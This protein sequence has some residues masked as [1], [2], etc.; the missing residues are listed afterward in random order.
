MNTINI[1]EKKCKFRIFSRNGC[2][3]LASDE[4]SIIYNLDKKENTSC[5][6]QIYTKGLSKLFKTII[7]NWILY[8]LFINKA[9][10]YDRKC[11]NHL[12]NNLVQIDNE[13]QYFESQIRCNSTSAAVADK[14]YY[15]FF[16]SNY[17]IQIIVINQNHTK[18]I[19]III[20]NCSSII[21]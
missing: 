3:A 7:S 14:M 1:K 13:P 15:L 20:I 6:K 2:Y 16:G 9:T 12:F 19:I 5:A 21:Y 4:W 18:K 10:V 8:K 11:L 17:S